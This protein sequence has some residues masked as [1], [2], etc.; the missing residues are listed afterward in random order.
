MEVTV[1]ASLACTFNRNEPPLAWYST[2][3]EAFVYGNSVDK[4]LLPLNRIHQPELLVHR[5]DPYAMRTAVYDDA[6][7]DD[8]LKELTKLG[9]DGFRFLDKQQYDEAFAGESWGSFCQ[10]DLTLTF[11]LTSH[12]MPV[13]R[14]C[15]HWGSHSHRQPGDARLHGVR[16]HPRRAAGAR[17]RKA[18]VCYRRAACV[19]RW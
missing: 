11:G 19:P 17:V 16:R 3:R 1:A 12:R 5:D 15:A 7:P 14:T 10:M 2:K 9:R 4:W 6:L 18:L 13:P 8:V